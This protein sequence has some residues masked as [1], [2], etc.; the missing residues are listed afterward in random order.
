MSTSGT[1]SNWTKVQHPDKVFHQMTSDTQLTPFYFGGSQVPINLG[2]K[3]GSG[4]KKDF[5]HSKILQ[6]VKDLQGRGIHTTYEHTDRIMMPKHMR[7]I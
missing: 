7:R 2:I 1:Y 6:Q 3:T 5:Y 4:I